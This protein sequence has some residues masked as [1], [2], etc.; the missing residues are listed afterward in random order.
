[1]ALKKRCESLR[2]NRLSHYGFIV[3]II[4]F[5][6]SLIFGKASFKKLV[7]HLRGEICE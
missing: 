2:K 6:Y 4:G 1:M 5:I 7:S 3:S